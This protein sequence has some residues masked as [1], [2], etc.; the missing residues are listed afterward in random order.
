LS[1][2][3]LEALDLSAELRVH[4]EAAQPRRFARVAPFPNFTPRTSP[5]LD[6]GAVGKHIGHDG[7]GRCSLTMAARRP[8]SEWCLRV[9]GSSVTGA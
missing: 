5:R 8:V 2:S 4:V 9:R 1:E 6:D 3:N 7:R